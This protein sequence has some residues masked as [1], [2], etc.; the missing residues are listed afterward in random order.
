MLGVIITV[1]TKIGNLVEVFVFLLFSISIFEC[2]PLHYLILFQTKYF[3]SGDYNMARA[4]M[5]SKQKI[6]PEVKHV[7][8]DHM[9]TPD[10]MPRVRK[11][12][13]STLVT[14]HL[15]LPSAT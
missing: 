1:N 6:A 15:N 8:G 12:S 14:G 5:A 9:P 7:T 4:Q 3:D 11:A 13:Q 2:C 10:E